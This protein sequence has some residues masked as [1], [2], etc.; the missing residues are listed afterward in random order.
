MKRFT[1]INV[2]IAHKSSM[3][4]VCISDTEKNCIKNL[5]KI[6]IIVFLFSFSG[7]GL[8]PWQI[9]SLEDLT[10]ICCPECIFKSKDSEKFKNHAL[11]NHPDSRDFFKTPSEKTDFKDLELSQAVVFPLKDE[12]IDFV[13]FEPQKL[14][15]SNGC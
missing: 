13:S 5:C 10:F 6:Q 7:M 2:Q 1:I 8:N 4:L 3:F 9:E 12:N 11:E 14:N 15:Y